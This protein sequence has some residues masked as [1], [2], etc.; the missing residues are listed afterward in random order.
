MKSDLIGVLSTLGTCLVLTTGCGTSQ[1]EKVKDTVE[2]VEQ[3]VKSQLLTAT[4]KKAQERPIGY[5]LHGPYDLAGT[6]TKDSEQDP[7]WK[8]DATLTFPTGGYTV[9]EPRIISTRSM[10]EQINIT[11]PVSS[12]P[13][14][15]MVT[16]A[17]TTVPVSK[18]FPG[19]N[20]ATIRVFIGVN[21]GMETRY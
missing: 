17:L 8:M 14:D 21:Q 11:I 3:T 20:G 4:V 7:T 6:I 2:K 16:Q 13:P 18:E 9:G 19:T 10:P 15:A 12:P 1:K 5:Q